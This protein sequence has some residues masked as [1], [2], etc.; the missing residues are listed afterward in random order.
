MKTSAKIIEFPRQ[1]TKRKRALRPFTTYY[2]RAPKAV[3]PYKVGHASSTVN[4]IRAALPSLDERQAYLV[5][6]CDQYGNIRAEV[7]VHRNEMTI[8]RWGRN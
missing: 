8:T 4:A 1:Q 5:Q 6:V 2:Y 3:H 7:R